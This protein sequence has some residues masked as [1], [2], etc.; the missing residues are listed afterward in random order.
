LIKPHPK[1]FDVPIKDILP[2]RSDVPE[3]FFDHYNKWHN[4]VSDMFFAGG[5][6]PPVKE[7]VDLAQA[8]RHMK[9]VLSSWEPE[10]N[11][12]IAGV[13]YLASQWFILDEEKKD[14]ENDADSD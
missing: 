6:L 13:A 14:E 3:E 7:G 4:F 5:K 12:K 10:H 1:A 8:A 9:A 2:K 11:H